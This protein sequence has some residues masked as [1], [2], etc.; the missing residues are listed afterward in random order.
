[1]STLLSESFATVA[2][3]E[4]DTQLARDSS[5]RLATHKLGRRSS[6]RIQL[7][8]DGKAAEAVAVPASA[9]RLFLHALDSDPESRRADHAAG[10][11]S[12]QRLPALPGVRF[13]DLMAYKQAADLLNVS[14]PYLGSA[15]TTSWPTSG[16]MT[17]PGP[18][19]SVSWRPKPRNSGWATDGA[20]G[21]RRLRRQYSLP[22][23]AARPVHSLMRAQA[24]PAPRETARF[25]SAAERPPRT[26]AGRAARPAVPWLGTTRYNESAKGRGSSA[27]GVES[28]GR[29]LPWQGSFTD[30]AR[31]GGGAG[32][33]SRLFTFPI[34]APKVRS[35]SRPTT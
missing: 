1:M 14:R 6:V 18:R 12:S 27:A 3:T 34:P 13:D 4:A 20:S 25:Q 22:G 28:G 19:S 32:A 17:R 35:S 23:S 31:S 26:A 5:R 10:R 11:R 21:Y 2:P 29:R 15:S 8:D 9:L 30:T 16:R 33:I 24:S 7:L